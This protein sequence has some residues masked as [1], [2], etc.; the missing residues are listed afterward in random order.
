MSVFLKTSIFRHFA[1][2][3]VVVML[4]NFLSM[5]PNSHIHGGA[6][7]PSMEV[8]VNKMSHDS[9]NSGGD[10]SKAMEECGMASCSLV[11][12]RLISDLSP[13][14][15]SDDAFRLNGDRF[16]SLRSGPLP[17]PPKFVA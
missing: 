13:L 4:A 7:T 16:N 6:D 9:S 1:L 15:A 14:E 11:M 8:S 5:L 10:F 3:M 12:P 2:A 17:R